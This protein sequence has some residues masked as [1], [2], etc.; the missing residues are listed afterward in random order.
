M[1]C[2]RT[3]LKWGR[4]VTLQPSE[5]PEFPNTH[6]LMSWVTWLDLSIIKHLLNME[7]FGY[8][9][10]R[11][12]ETYWKIPTRRP[13]LRL[14]DELFTQVP[15]MQPFPQCVNVKTIVLTARSVLWIINFNI[16]QLIDKSFL[17]LDWK[18][19]F[20]F[21][22]LYFNIQSKYMI[23]IFLWRFDVFMYAFNSSSILSL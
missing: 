23:L 16:S 22:K 17:A 4:R 12:L 9:D 21:L 2:Q 5:P 7:G 14:K 18:E 3:Q 8:S 1:I 6:V 15:W 11:K 13:T 10:K 19:T 20:L